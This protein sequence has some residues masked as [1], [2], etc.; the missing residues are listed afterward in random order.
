M[1]CQDFEELAGAH[2]LGALTEEE[3]QRADEHLA[4]CP[5]CQQDY[6]E[7]QAVVNLLPL[8]VPVVKPSP[9][10]GERI[11]A[12]I[13]MNE[14]KLSGSTERARWPEK[15][16][17]RKNISWGM[18]L[19]TVAAALLLLLVGG[20]TT[21]NIVLQHQLAELTTQNT[22]PISYPIQGSKESTQVNG[23]FI[24]YPQQHISI[25]LVHGLPALK[26]GQVYQGWLLRDSHPSSIGLFNLQG[27]TATLTFPGAISGYDTAAISREPGPQA[28]QLAPKGTV[29]ATGSLQHLQTR[30]EGIVLHQATVHASETMLSSLSGVCQF[31]VSLEDRRGAKC[32]Y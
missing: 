14:A 19:L 15:T 21:W 1:D 17:T 20:M 2:A 18:R 13:Q 31:L 28:S 3:Q 4:Q 32:E 9:M 25:L 29:I 7:M 10:L 26:G 24:Y 23:Q 30:S 6:R 16:R 27:D 11:I 5:N 8:A 12:R 22:A